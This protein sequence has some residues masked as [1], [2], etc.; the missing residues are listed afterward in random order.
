[1]SKTYRITNTFSGADL[2]TYE[3]TSEKGALD[4]M[5]RLAGY[6]DHASA[7]EAAHVNDGELSV[8]VDRTETTRLAFVAYTESIGSTCEAEES[9]ILSV[10]RELLPPCAIAVLDG[11]EGTEEYY[12][13]LQSQTEQAQNEHDAEVA[14]GRERS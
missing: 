12:A 7:C 8:T 13:F 11:G 1:M 2:G 5:A 6:V 4:A 9:A 3:A 10:G 14:A